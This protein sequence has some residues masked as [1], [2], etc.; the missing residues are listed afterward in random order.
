MHNRWGQKLPHSLIFSPSILFLHSTFKASLQR[1]AGGLNAHALANRTEISKRDIL[2]LNS[3]YLT[4]LLFL[5]LGMGTETRYLI[6][7]GAK[8]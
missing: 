2:V 4:K 5:Y 6:G 7:L 3:S 1:T 8:L